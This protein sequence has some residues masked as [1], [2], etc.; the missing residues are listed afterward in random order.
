MSKYN[1]FTFSVLTLFGLIFFLPGLSLAH[2]FDWDEINFAE[3]AREMLVTGDWAM[4]QINYEPFWEKPPLFIW[5]QAISMKIFGVNE[6][7]A[8]F[9][10]VLSAI[11][12]LNF[13]YYLG[14]KYFRPGVAQWWVIAYVGALFPQFYFRTGLIDPTFNLFIFIAIHQ[15]AKAYQQN[16]ISINNSKSLVLSALFIGLSILVKGPA[17]LLIYLIVL[18]CICIANRG[19]IFSFSQFIISAVIVVLITSIWFLPETLKNG[20]WFIKRFVVYQIELAS[21]NVAGHAQPWFYHP[22]VLF[23]G[24]VP[25]SVL[26]I[27]GMRLKVKRHQERPFYTTYHILFWVVLIVFSI[28][29]TKI[30]HY[31]S[32]CWLPMTFLAAYAIDYMLQNNINL[33]KSGKLL[34]TLSMLPLLIIQ[35]G[36]GVLIWKPSI[37]PIGIIE[38]PFVLSMLNTKVTMHALKVIFLLVM[39]I[40]F[41]VSFI[42]TLKNFKKVKLFFGV[43]VINIFALTMIM[44][45]YV[46]GKM[47]K[48]LF[49]FYKSMQNKDVYIET[50][51]FKSYAHYFYPRIKPLKNTDGL[52]KLRN[53]F[54]Q[55]QKL[56][57]LSQD[58][59]E[60]WSNLKY[61]FHR[62]DPRDK[63]IYL[64][65]KKGHIGLPQSKEGF[66]EL[67]D[68]GSYKV[69]LRKAKR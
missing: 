42:L 19:L 13:I 11:A 6:F 22:L 12:T 53:T 67:K 26:A 10:T 35:I 69:F 9:P 2:L 31:S 14:L 68:K 41:A 18:V 30:I 25:I 39:G 49:D 51:H 4:V 5:M 17:A 55:G 58:S 52:V 48:P 46:D 29:K 23:F 56:Q 15:L 33:K 20:T 61:D 62:A 3:A 21:Q 24:C 54:L 64:V 16:I 27:K 40:L 59:S 37:F 32:L 43:S 60:M 66:F 38:D 28:V 1:L 34:W 50:M 44:V 7:G 47:Q 8:R 63:D 45:P 36:V 65:Y 57:D